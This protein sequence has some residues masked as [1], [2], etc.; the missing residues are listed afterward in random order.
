MQRMTLRR[1]LQDES[2]FVLPMAL[3]MIV[4]LATITAGIFL[5][6]SNDLPIAKA[7]QSRRGAL[8]AA[9]AGAAWYAAK[10]AADP[11]YWIKCASVADPDGGPRPPVRAAPWNGVGVDPRYF[12]AI[13]GSTSSYTIELLPAN[14]A[15]GCELATASRP[16]A[17]A[18]TMLNANRLRIRATGMSGGKRRSLIVTFRR[19]SFLDYVYYTNYEVLDPQALPAGATGANANCANYYNGTPNRQGLGCQEIQWATGDLVSGPLHTNDQ[20][21]I[22]GSPVFGDLPTDR[23]EVGDPTACRGTTNCADPS[24]Y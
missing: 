1:R 12:R 3:T 20:L 7:D 16:N 21:N 2:G 22:N 23:I 9:Q 15:A 24:R 4:L 11:D 8:D 5:A 13:P 6:T 18:E 19:P 10:L 14:G 17:P